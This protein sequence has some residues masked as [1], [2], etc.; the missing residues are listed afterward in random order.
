MQ[1]LKVKLYY[2]HY[3]HNQQQIIFAWKNGV[4]KT[5]TL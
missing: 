5:A 1:I 4:N 3:D 2:N